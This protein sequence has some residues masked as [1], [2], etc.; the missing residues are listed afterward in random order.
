MRDLET[1]GVG[2]APGWGAGG[3]EDVDIGREVVGV[4]CGCDCVGVGRV[5][6]GMG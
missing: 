4:G 3:E 5:E 6:L 2:R 1:K